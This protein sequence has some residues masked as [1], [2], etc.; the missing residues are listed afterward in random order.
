MA[1]WDLPKAGVSPFDDE[2]EDHAAWIRERVAELEDLSWYFDEPEVLRKVMADL[3]SPEPELRHAARAAVLNLG[4]REAIP[5][6]ESG[7][8][9]TD[10]PS[11]K[12]ALLEAAD[13]LKLPTVLEVG[14][15]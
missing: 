4:S 7:A 11:E 5:Y 12:L 10:V 3:R 14:E 15:R 6:L 8:A 2:S 1:G 9:L 13:Y